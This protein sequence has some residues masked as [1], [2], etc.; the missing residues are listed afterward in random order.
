MKGAIAI[1]TRATYQV[2]AKAITI[3]PSMEALASA[4]TARASVLTPLR[5]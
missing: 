1:A 2:K 3:P 4:A 5:V